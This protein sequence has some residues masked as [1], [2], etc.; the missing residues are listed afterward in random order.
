VTTTFYAE[1]KSPLNQC[2]AMLYPEISRE[3]GGLPTGTFGTEI[4]GR[5]ICRP[6]GL[7]GTP[8]VAMRK[9]DIPC[10][11]TWSFKICDRCQ[12]LAS[13]RTKKLRGSPYQLPPT[14]FPRV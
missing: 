14:L 13:I 7:P 4:K 8:S 1:Q 5:P 10:A 3:N 6:Y 9:T 11:P 2:V 12:Y